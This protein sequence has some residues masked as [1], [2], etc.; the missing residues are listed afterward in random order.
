MFVHRFPKQ[1]NIYGTQQI[2]NRINQD[3]TISQQLNLWSQGGS[4]IFRGN[5]LAI[6]IED[7]L[8]YVEPIYIKSSNKTSLP[9]VK[10]IV[11]AY[12]EEIEKEPKSNEALDK[13]FQLI[14]PANEGEKVKDDEND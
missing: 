1:K 6:P 10:Q 4:E 5:L 3:S 11:I 14:D 2:E 12:G 8:F 13:K 7:T 9:E